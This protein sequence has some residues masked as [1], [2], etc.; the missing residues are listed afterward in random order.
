[1]STKRRRYVRGGWKEQWD[2]APAE[3]KRAEQ[4]GEVDTGKR[5]KDNGLLEKLW[6]FGGGSPPSE[7]VIECIHCGRRFRLGDAKVIASSLF[8]EAANPEGWH[9]CCPYWPRCDGTVIDFLEVR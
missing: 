2:H 5:L 7:E 3:I 6:P 8:C 9:I 1:M 4:Y